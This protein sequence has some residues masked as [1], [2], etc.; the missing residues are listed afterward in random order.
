MV[1]GFTDLIEC[2]QRIHNE[3]HNH[4]R[5]FQ[6]YEQWGWIFLSIYKT[7]FH[8]DRARKPPNLFGG[9]IAPFQ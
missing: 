4:K 7:E 9:G 3:D 5:F 2:Y 8:R 1:H 6:Q